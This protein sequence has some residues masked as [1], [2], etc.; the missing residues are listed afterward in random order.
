MRRQVDAQIRSGVRALLCLG[1]MGMAQMHI[2]EV[3]EQAIRVTLDE[4]AGRIPVLAGCGDCRTS[5]TL[6]YVRVAERYHPDA[7]V[8]ITPYFPKLTN[9][10][11][12]DYFTSIATATSIPIY[13]YDIPFYTNRPLS[14]SL[15]GKL[16][17]RNKNIVGVK[18]SGEFATLRECIQYFWENPNFSV[19]SGHSQFLDT[20]LMMGAD[21][22]VDGLFAL[23]PKIGVDLYDAA[24]RGDF[25]GALEAQRRPPAAKQTT[26]QKSWNRPAGKSRSVNQ[27]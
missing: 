20:A 23:A 1:S 6:Q 19:L 13:L 21:G 17:A 12:F 7:I 9:E 4:A 26:L 16:A 11:L 3:R 15:I 24:R 18:A 10:E 27:A 5:R 14:A 2:A 8:L 22:I 25:D